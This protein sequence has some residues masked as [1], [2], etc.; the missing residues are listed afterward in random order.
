MPRKS[1]AGRLLQIMAVI[2]GLISRSWLQNSRQEEDEMS[3]NLIEVVDKFAPEDLDKGPIAVLNL[4][5]FKPGG[6][7]S[8]KR[9]IEE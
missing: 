6:E 5:K 4:L 1:A 7:A 8:Y 3:F 9:Y 2:S